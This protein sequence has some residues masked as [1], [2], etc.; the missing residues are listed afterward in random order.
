MR[1][2]SVVKIGRTS[3]HSKGADSQSL[4]KGPQIGDTDVYV[5]LFDANGGTIGLELRVNTH[6]SGTQS[7]PRMTALSDGGY[8]VTWQDFS[9]IDGSG[10]QCSGPTFRRIGQRC[11]R[12][13]SAQ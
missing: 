8:F 11:R 5:Q 4:G 3:L 1:P 2:E 9:G 12:K 7:A 13:H 6:I 10:L